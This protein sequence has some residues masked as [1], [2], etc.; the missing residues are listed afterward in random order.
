[1]NFCEVN[2]LWAEIEGVLRRKN[3]YGSREFR[4]WLSL[5]NLKLN[6]DLLNISLFMVDQANRLMLFCGVM[7]QRPNTSNA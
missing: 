1:M 3:V 4:M 7:L 2:R 5:K 6:D